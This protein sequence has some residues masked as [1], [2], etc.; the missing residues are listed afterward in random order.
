MS[1]SLRQ[2]VNGKFAG[3][4]RTLRWG[5]TTISTY[6]PGKTSWVIETRLR[7][8]TF[9]R[10]L[11]TKELWDLNTPLETQALLD[12][13]GTLRDVLFTDSLIAKRRFG[14]E[15]GILWPRIEYLQILGN[16][17]FFSPRGLNNVKG[18]TFRIT[19]YDNPI[20]PPKK[21]S[22]YVRNPSSVGSKRRLPRQILDIEEAFEEYADETSFLEFLTV[23]R[24]LGTTLVL[25]PSP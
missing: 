16:V 9:L 14:T 1:S 23:G 10:L 15:L 5:S 25:N 24:I 17:S 4:R 20:R 11:K 7:R 2:F 19:E 6:N 13:P 3:P 8:S 12:E 21:Y 22:G 18:Q